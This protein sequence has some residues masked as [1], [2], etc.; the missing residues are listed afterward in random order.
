M[1]LSK[2]RPTLL[3]FILCL[4][5][6]LLIAGAVLMAAQPMY[7]AFIGKSLLREPFFILAAAAALVIAVF[8]VFPARKPWRLFK[9]LFRLVVLAIVVA[10]I[11]GI[12]GFWQAQ[13]DMLYH[14][15]RRELNAEAALKEDPRAEEITIEGAQGQ[16]WHGFM[17]MPQPGQAGLV[18]Y[19]GGN[20]ELAAGRVHTLVRDNLAQLLG[21]YHF[22]MVDYPGYGQSTGEPEEA[23]VLA[24]ARAALD[25]ARSRPD[26]LKDRIVIAGWSLG[27]VPAA[28]LAA[29]NTAAGLILM[30]P[31][32]NG[33]ELVNGYVQSAFHAKDA[34][35][36]RVPGFL[37]R[38]KF[39][40]D[41]YARQ[42]A[43]PALIISG[44]ADEMIP[45][46]QAERLSA[47]YQKGSLLTL[48][49]G[50]AAPWS[51][52]A[53]AQAITQFLAG[54]ADGTL[55]TE[56]VTQLTLP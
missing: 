15:G 22:M 53:S 6:G 3:R 4:F 32:Y 2:K 16:R 8:L 45:H 21:G 30:S 18:L 11:F 14:P 44:R 46:S 50:H 47:L 9:W 19:F 35:Y 25:Y 43:I 38:N 33:R 7:E 37:V 12:G 13:N 48:E 40:N 42:T 10:L 52:Q 39:P 1:S 55:N 26:V 34:F 28:A 56:Q 27:S 54:V 31:P 20:G 5:I 24:M 36:T 17:F 51:E 29:D 23:T 41:T 49:G